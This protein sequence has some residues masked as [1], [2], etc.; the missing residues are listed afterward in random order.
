MSNFLHERMVVTYVKPAAF[1][2]AVIVKEDGGDVVRLKGVKT[3]RVSL[4]A[5]NF[6]EPESSVT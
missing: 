4:E 3:A 5:F 1:Q 2:A 6:G